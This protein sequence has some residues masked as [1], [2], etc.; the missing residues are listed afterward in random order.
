VVRPLTSGSIVALRY[1]RM[2][3]H[4]LALLGPAL[5]LFALVAKP[6]AFLALMFALQVALYFVFRALAVPRRPKSFGSIRGKGGK[7][8][9]RAIVRL[10]DA[11]YHKLLEMQVGDF[12]GRYGFLA[13]QGEYE[14]S[15]EA[16]GYQTWHGTASVGPDGTAVARDIQLTPAATP[17]PAPQPK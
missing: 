5:S 12:R 1:G 6:T 2:A 3:Q 13:R 4:G 11:K 14:L 15:V 17:P 7:P 10:F 8:V 16:A 9:G